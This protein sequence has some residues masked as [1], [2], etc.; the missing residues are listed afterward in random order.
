MLEEHFVTTIKE[1]RSE[2]LQLLSQSDREESQVEK[3]SNEAFF[4]VFPS[5]LQQADERKV[6]ENEAL[7]EEIRTSL[8]EQ[9]SKQLKAQY[10]EQK[11]QQ[12]QAEL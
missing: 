8:A 4:K 1:L 3:Y 6:R 5:L 9:V 11:K 10:R 12:C 2:C 7:H